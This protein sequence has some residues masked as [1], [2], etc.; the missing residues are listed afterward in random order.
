MT[1]LE[2]RLWAADCWLR[3]M[4]LLIKAYEQNKPRDLICRLESLII[5]IDKYSD[6]QPR[7]EHGR[8][9][10]GGGSSGENSGGENSVVAEESETASNAH[11]RNE[12]LEKQIKKCI[13]APDPVFADDLE[14]NFRKI[15][16]E[17]G[18]YI[19]A[20]HGTAD[21]VELFGTKADEK[22]LSN[23]LKSRKDYNGEE[24]V[25]IS[26]NTGNTDTSS[27][28]FAQKLANKTGK[29]VYAPTRYGAISSN[30]EYYS[31]DSK[32]KRKVGSFK[33]F[34]PKIE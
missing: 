12:E 16:K 27:N 34:K 8:W 5:E 24:I 10:S 32:G 13:D 2:K 33:R 26:C 23:I 9:T 31:S 28:C 18:K 19:I 22:V 30:G 3:C 15:P 21:S 20:M 7:D 11:P 4:E 25:L 6:D 1:D 29:I 14:K 17:N